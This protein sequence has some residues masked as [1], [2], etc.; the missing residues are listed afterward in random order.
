ML[1]P[2]LFIQ[3]VKA[4]INTEIKK[5]ERNFM[6]RRSVIWII[7]VFLLWGCAQRVGPGGGPADE[8]PPVVERFFPQRSA[9]G[10]ALDEAVRF[11]FSEWISP[12]SAEKAV[13]VF[14]LLPGGFSVTVK[15]RTLII[16]PHEQFEKD[17][18]YH[19]ELST[20]L[21]DLRGNNLASAI[22]LIFSTGQDLDSAQFIG[23]IVREQPFAMPPKLAFFSTDSTIV[24]T[25]RYVAQSDSFGY[26]AMEHVAKDSFVVVAFIDG[27]G[28]NRFQP[29]KEDLFTALSPTLATAI[30]AAPV[31]FYPSE[32]DTS[33]LR[34]QEVSA[35]ADTLLQVRLSRS[36]E[37][38]DG[39]LPPWS[40]Y[41]DSLE[42]IGAGKVQQIKPALFWVHLARPLEPGRYMLTSEAE[43]M[44]PFLLADSLRSDTLRFNFTPVED[45]LGAK[46]A[47]RLG[48]QATALSPKLV[49]TTTELVQFTTDS[50][51]LLQPDS[52][53]QTLKRPMPRD[54]TAA[55]A[56]TLEPRQHFDTL[57]VGALPAGYFDSVVVPVHHKLATGKRY[58]VR[59]EPQQLVDL[60]GNPLGD[61]SFSFSFSIP[62]DT[63]LN[64]S[65]TVWTDCVFECPSV[66][67]FQPATRGASAWSQSRS[68]E[69]EFTF[70][71]IDADSGLVTVF[72][73][74]NRNRVWDA[75]SVYPFVAP[76][77]IHFFTDTLEARARWDISGIF[78]KGCRSCKKRVAQPLDI[79]S[80]AAE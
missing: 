58:V 74:C 76:E 3:R 4:L 26:V 34:I 15:A 43:P 52:T 22:R 67:L 11:E 32:A 23:C 49:L 54:T 44:P 62:S 48:R 18:T 70:T 12:A 41:N 65:F 21:T 79:Q 61:S 7:Q 69:G 64:L 38:F 42:P 36:A 63:A 25:P 17:R 35:L 10:V 30:D 46:I 45:T 19:V 1:V 78:L 57:K 51:L 14:P 75:G 20:G 40:L 2:A 60:A 5:A 28:D 66:M 29:R 16:E 27:N 73:D 31:F 53:G 71:T 56:D 47:I 55:A 13:S 24:A 37:D 39:T 77:P 6:H 33:E 80:E 9:T 50:I 72:G 68:R 8:T 59:I